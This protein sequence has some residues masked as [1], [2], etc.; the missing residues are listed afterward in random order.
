VIGLSAKAL[1]LA[2]SA[3]SI[4]RQ[5]SI[6]KANEIGPEYEGFKEVADISQEIDSV[7]GEFEQ[8]YERARR[9]TSGYP[10]FETLTA[11]SD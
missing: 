10:S 2:I 5:Q 1:S 9:L 8:E 11:E 6:D 4:M 7:M 3:L